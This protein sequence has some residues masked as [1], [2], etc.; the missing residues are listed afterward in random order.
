ME[1]SFKTLIGTH[2]GK[3][4]VVDGYVIVRDIGLGIE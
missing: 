2:P 1:G 4:T 3:P